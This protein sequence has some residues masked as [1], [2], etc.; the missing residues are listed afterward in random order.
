ML[1]IDAN[2]KHPDTD[3]IVNAIKVR[4]F[5][6]TWLFRDGQNFTDL[7]SILTETDRKEIL[8][9]EFVKFLL[10]EFWS[11]YKREL[12]LRMFIPYMLYSLSSFGFMYMKLQLLHGLAEDESYPAGLAIGGILTVIFWIY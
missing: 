6:L 8:A 1:Q 9:T 10:D 11:S 5:N 3:N 7:V 12:V 2:D 4:K